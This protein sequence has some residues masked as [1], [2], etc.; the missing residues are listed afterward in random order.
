[1]FDG[2]SATTTEPTGA[3]YATTYNTVSVPY[4]SSV[5]NQTTPVYVDG[6]GRVQ[7]CLLSLPST[8]EYIDLS[9]S[10]DD[11]VIEDGHVYVFSFINSS[12]GSV[13][14]RLF[15]TSTTADVRAQII[16]RKDALGTSCCMVDL[17]YDSTYGNTQ[18][19]ASYNVTSSNAG[20]VLN[21][22]GRRMTVNGVAYDY[23][24][25]TKQEGYLQ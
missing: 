11:L 1:M 19:V 14:R 24:E 10:S 2:K 22:H 9:V 18:A 20:I 12:G 13:V 5:G 17:V 23:F 4:S 15:C 25:V 7:P 3:V 6:N 21:L 8:A 16:I